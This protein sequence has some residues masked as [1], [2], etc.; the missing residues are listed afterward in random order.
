MRVRRAWPCFGLTLCLLACVPEDSNE[1]PP[2]PFAGPDGS[3]GD[4]SV[5]DPGQDA[6]VPDPFTPPRSLVIATYNVE[7]L[8]DLRDDPDTD[9]GEFTPRAGQWDAAQ[10]TQRLTHLSR[11][12]IAL[13]ADVVALNELENV[14][15]LA[16]LRDAI[17]EA[18]GERYPYLGHANSRDP[19]GID[20]SLL[21]RYPVLFQIGRPINKAHPCLDED[22]APVTL[23]GS[24]PEARP[25]LQVDVN[26]DAD[27]EADLTFLVNHWKAKGRTSFPC[28]DDEHRLRS[29]HF[30]AELVDG[31]R[32][33]RPLVGIIAMGDFNAFEFEAPLEQA[34]DA[35]LV[36]DPRPRL[37]NAWAGGGVTPHDRNDNRWNNAQNSSYNFSG[38]W[39]RLDHL[40]LTPD[41]V[42]GSGE[43]RLVPDSMGPLSAGYLLSGG[44]P[45]SWDLETGAGYS[46]HLPVR[47]TLERTD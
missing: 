6:V 12:L 24:H 22:G 25:V 20:V 2:V 35:R 33:D 39:T 5:T 45:S 30:L 36:L 23:D 16:Q 28:D 44:R 31:L 9:E 1:G 11:V 26:V 41:L 21:S 46:D 13:D 17:V 40:L 18:G 38:D 19:R 42:D 3:G 14:E 27:P 37:F 4:A 32:R 29:G 7:N 8:F 43:W 15:V 34:L 10:L 47:L